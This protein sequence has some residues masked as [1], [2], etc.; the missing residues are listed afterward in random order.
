MQSESKIYKTVLSYYNSIIDTSNHFT[1]TNLF[2]G[3]TAGMLG[4]KDLG[5]DLIWGEGRIPQN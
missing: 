5:L 1:E 2:Y 4:Y 3:C